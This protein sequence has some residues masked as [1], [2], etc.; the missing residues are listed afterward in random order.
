MPRGNDQ[1]PWV[2]LAGLPESP[3]PVGMFGLT[4]LP[5]F[6]LALNKFRSVTQC[7]ET[8]ECNDGNDNNQCD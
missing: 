8:Y 6:G 1:L 4:P 7:Y 5:S 3:E 2:G